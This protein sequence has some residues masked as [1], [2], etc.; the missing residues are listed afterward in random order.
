MD[1]FRNS[2]SSA[3]NLISVNSNSLICTVC[4]LYMHD[5]E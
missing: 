1:N 4:I 3:I 2:E 5:I